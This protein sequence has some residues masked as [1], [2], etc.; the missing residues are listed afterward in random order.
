MASAFRRRSLLA[1]LPAL[2]LAATASRPRA[3]AEGADVLALGH[4]DPAGVTLVDRSRGEVRR[5]LPLG[6]EPAQLLI[7]G[8]GRRLLA[9][10]YD[11]GLTLLPLVD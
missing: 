5:H 6:H 4:L 9:S 10:D 3:A 1:A 2:A 7:D 8:R 11:N